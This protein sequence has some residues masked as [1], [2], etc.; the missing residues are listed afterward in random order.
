MT[1]EKKSCGS[2]GRPRCTE[3]ADRILVAAFELLVEKGWDKFTIE[4]VATKAGVSKATVYRWWCDR[5]SLAVD[6]FIAQGCCKD[7]LPDTGCLFGDL[8]EQ[9]LK[10]VDYMT[11]DHAN[12]LRAVFVAVQEQP[13]LMEKLEQHWSPMRKASM[14]S[15]VNTAIER[16]QL[17][18]GTDGGMLFQM[19]T[20]PILMNVLFGKTMTR[21]EV[22]PMVGQVLMSFGFR[23]EASL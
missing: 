10:L 8:Q 15:L 9:I 5:H 13:E 21:E 6:S 22:R 23:E 1:E 17:P 14:D 16:G 12:A 7:A 3:A 20:G 18:P 2:R 4:G 19:V 11:G